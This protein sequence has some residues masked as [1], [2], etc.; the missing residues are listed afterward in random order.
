MVEFLT[1]APAK[2]WGF[3]RKKLVGKAKAWAKD[4]LPVTRRRM[5]ETLESRDSANAR[6]G[7]WRTRYRLVGQ[8]G[9]FLYALKDEYRGDEPFHFV[10]PSCF[11]QGK[12]GILQRT[13]RTE[14]TTQGPIVLKEEVKEGLVCAICDYFMSTAETEAS[15]T[16]A[17]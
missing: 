10:C 14:R 2:A 1:A 7:D 12:K 6:L 4:Y 11:G 3:L 8:K 5:R 13:T 15:E 17:E 9:V 16:P